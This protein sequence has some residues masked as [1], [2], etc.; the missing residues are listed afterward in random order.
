MEISSEIP[1]IF[2]IVNHQAQLTDVFENRECNPG[3]ISGQNVIDALST[4]VLAPFSQG[5][6]IDHLLCSE[7]P[8]R[9]SSSSH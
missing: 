6:L 5:T 2:F 3:N 8:K 1:L 7:K 9:T 4:Q